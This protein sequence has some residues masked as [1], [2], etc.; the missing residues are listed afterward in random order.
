VELILPV[1]IFFLISAKILL[2]FQDNKDNKFWDI[3][4][5]VKKKKP[6]PSIG[7]A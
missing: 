7:Q 3:N 4:V 2:F 6:A 1:K 5:T